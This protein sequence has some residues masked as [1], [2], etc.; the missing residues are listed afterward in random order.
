[1]TSRDKNAEGI[2]RWA[3]PWAPGWSDMRHQVH[4]L[5]KNS[6]SRI[7]RVGIAATSVAATVWLV[8]LV[9]VWQVIA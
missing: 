3:A 1:M 6:R 9:W 8:G 7:Q 4:A 2:P 5:P